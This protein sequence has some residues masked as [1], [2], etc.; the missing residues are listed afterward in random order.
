[1]SGR[2]PRA[3]LCCK[4]GSYRAGFLRV[5]AERAKV[6]ACGGGRGV[7]HVTVVERPDGAQPLLDQRWPH[8]VEFSWVEAVPNRDRRAQYTDTRTAVQTCFSQEGQQRLCVAWQHERLLERVRWLQRWT[9]LE[10]REPS[11]ELLQGRPVG[12]APGLVV[13][14]NGGQGS[15]QAAPRRSRRAAALC[16]ACG[17]CGR[18]RRDGVVLLAECSSCNHPIRKFGNSLIL[19]VRRMDTTGHAGWH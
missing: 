14:K 6:G 5:V 18:R 3:K 2:T 7:A 1:M 19:P 17:H 15:A 4:R 8:V 12:L 11:H 9:C 16:S 13:C 10:P